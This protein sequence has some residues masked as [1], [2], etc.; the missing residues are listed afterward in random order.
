MSDPYLARVPVWKKVALT[1]GFFAIVGA[2]ALAH[3]NPATAYEVSL[4]SETPIGVWIGLGTA[5]AISLVVA[6]TSLSPADRPARVA[7]LGLGGIGTAVFA[8]MPLVR[9]Y[10][11]LGQNDSLTHLG[12]TIAISDGVLSPFELFYPALHLNSVVID[13]VLGISLTQAMLLVVVV[14]IVAYVTFVPLAARAIVPTPDVVVTAAFAGFLLV[15]ITTIA[16]HLHPHTMS[17]TVL[18]SALFVY[19]LTKYLVAPN[20]GSTAF[21]LLLAAS[22]GA[23]VLFHPQLVAHMLVVMIAIAVLQR[24]SADASDSTAN[25]QPI[26]GQTLFVAGLFVLWTGYHGLLTFATDTVGSAVFSV[27]TGESEES[28]IE[29]QGASLEAIGA[30]LGE[31]F[32]KLFLPQLVLSLFAAGLI[33]AVV[34]HRRTASRHPLSGITTYFAAGLAGLGVLFVVYYFSSTSQMHFRVFGLMMVFVTVLGA[35]SIAQGSEWVR[36]RTVPMGVN[37]VLAVGLGALLVCSL[38][39]TFPAPYT[40]NQNHHVPESTMSGYETA[41]AGT[42]PDTDILGLSP[43]ANRFNDVADPSD[44]KTR[45]HGSVNQSAGD[46]SLPA[47]IDPGSYFI[48]STAD[49]EREVIAYQELRYSAADFDEIE[50]ADGIHRLQTNGD[51]VLYYVPEER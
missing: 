28:A 11:F 19:L 24:R 12:W 49:Y 9:G 4:Y 47:S 45:E 41:F 51:V 7:A 2:A 33:L 34:L 48:T 14:S 17:Q 1:G 25:Y 29:T 18:F 3:T 37:S 22:G 32:V 8:G 27:I 44:G 42:D 43:R 5:M 23:F 6:L 30:G 20:R 46:Q 40:Y 26:Y 15:P 31:A 16:T 39:A 38:L 10:H 13:S 35:V 21:G 50:S 36:E